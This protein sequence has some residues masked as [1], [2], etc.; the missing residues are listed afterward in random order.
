MGRSYGLRF[1]SVVIKNKGGVVGRIIHDICPCC[2]AWNKIEI[3]K[4]EH[5]TY[6]RCV[7]CDSTF[8]KCFVDGITPP[9]YSYEGE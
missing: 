8:D 5:G 2:E 4:D 6:Y 7:S 3:L 1:P 9:E